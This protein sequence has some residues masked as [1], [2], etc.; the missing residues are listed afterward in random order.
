MQEITISDEKSH[1]DIDFV[2]RYL[3]EESYWAK[4]IPRDVVIQSIE[5]S[6]CFSIFYHEKQIGFARVITDQATFA[7]LCDVFI[8]ASFRGN[9]YSKQL[10]QFIMKYP[11]LQDVRVFALGT[12][13]AHGLYSQFGFLP[14]ATP[15]RRM[16]IRKE[17]PY[18]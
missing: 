15:E 7:Y 17:N 3:S 8:D 6:L 1:I 4:G 11:A 18:L 12:L 2:H 10:M 14:L 16:E 13:D 9:G 5:N